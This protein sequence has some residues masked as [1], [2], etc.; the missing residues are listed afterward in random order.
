SS[1]RLERFLQLCAEDN[2]QVCQPS[3]SAQYFHLL[4]RQAKRIWKKPLIVITP[5]GMLRLP[6]ASSNIDKFT[7]GKFDLVL[8]EHNEDFANASRMILCS[9]KVI[10]E[11]RTERAKRND[12]NTAIVAVEQFYPTPEKEL[13]ATF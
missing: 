6:A 7:S 12:A 3:T 9:G 11:L 10:H 5:K 13:R 2:M 1:A 4:R 8:D